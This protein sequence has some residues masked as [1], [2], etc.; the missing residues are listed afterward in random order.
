MKI[1]TEVIGEQVM[2]KVKTVYECERC[3]FSSSNESEALAHCAG[4]VLKDSCDEEELYKFDSEEDAKTWI[5]QFKTNGYD[6]RNVE[7]EGPGWYFLERYNKPCPRNCCM[8]NCIKLYPASELLYG[9]QR[10]LEQL[11][12]KI[13]KLENIVE[14][15]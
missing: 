11:Q 5:E 13:C 6:E 9:L 4:H 2:K 14:K 7:W 3:D 15:S 12:N 8:D 10:N 1:K